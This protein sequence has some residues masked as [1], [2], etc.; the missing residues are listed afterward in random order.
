MNATQT[1]IKQKGCKAVIPS[2]LAHQTEA[3]LFGEDSATVFYESWVVLTI[4]CNLSWGGVLY[5]SGV[6]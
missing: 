6:P 4:V 5:V 1:P 3:H 2:I